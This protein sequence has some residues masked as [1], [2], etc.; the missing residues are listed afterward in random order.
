M[1]MSF[2]TAL[3]N[4]ELNAIVTAL[5]ASATAK[6]YNGSKPASLGTPTGTLLATLTYGTD[7]TAANGGTA[8]GVSAGVL[9][10]GGFTQT[11]SSHV[12]GT[13]TFVRFS[14]S[15]GTAVIDIDIGAGAGNVQFTGSI[16]NA[17]NI[18]GSMAITA[19]NP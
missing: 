14:T 10:F 6:F 4:A 13:P 8:G 5:G 1:T 11:A 9:T 7:V 15:A 16:V 18:T 19:G 17:Q 3:R 12:S 2:S